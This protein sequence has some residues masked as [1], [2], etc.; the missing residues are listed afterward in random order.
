MQS[1]NVRFIKRV[2]SLV[3]L[4]IIWVGAIVYAEISYKEITC[5]GVSVKIESENEKSLLNK[6]DINEVV[7]SQGT[8]YYLD[9]PLDE[10]SLKKMEDRVK[11]IPLVKECEAHVDFSGKIV[12]S[13]QEYSPIARILN[14][15]LGTN[16]QPDQY[17]TNDGEFIGTSSLFTPRVLVVSGPYFENYRKDLKDEKSKTLLPLFKFINSDEFWKAQIAEVEVARDGGIVLYSTIG[18]TKIDFGLPIHIDSKFKKL[19]VFY[20]QIVPNKGWN[21]YEWVRLK[22][23]NQLICE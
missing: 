13:V 2:I 6:N 5:T 1:R 18:N 22:Y 11:R 10:I 8:Q 23:K 12:L 14:R 21:K 7:T 4:L 19:A 15:T 17:V 3:I 16:E 9:K 20:K